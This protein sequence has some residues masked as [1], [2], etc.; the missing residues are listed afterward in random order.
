MPLAEDTMELVERNASEYRVRQALEAGEFRLYY[1]PQHDATTHRILGAEAL[2]RWHHPAAGVIEPGS[3]LYALEATG[4]IAPVGEWAFRQAAED[5]QRWQRLGLP[6]LKLGVNVSPSQLTPENAEALAQRVKEM[7]SC[8]DL[9]IEISNV[10]LVSPV[11][12]VVAALHALRFA[13]ADISVQHFG[14]DDYTHKRV[15]SLP[16]D[17]LKIDR[18]FVCRLTEDP[19]VDDELSGMLMLARAYRLGSV[20][21]GVETQEQCD[22]LRELNCDLTQGYLHAPPMPADRF[23]WLLRA[24]LYARPDHEPRA[25]RLAY[26][27]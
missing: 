19:E 11:E 25:G 6:R 13:G 5:C 2:L 7:R 9:Q 27:A 14:L 8:C 18:S 21:E 23:E 4:L 10:H 12:G 17:A 15:W 20:A 22:R 26:D 24:E 16:I 1:Q 3:F